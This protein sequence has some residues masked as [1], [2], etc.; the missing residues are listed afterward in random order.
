MDDDATRQRG[1]LDE[2]GVQGLPVELDRI[3]NLPH[4]EPWGQT[5]FP[6][7]AVTGDNP[8]NA[9]Q[10]LLRNVLPVLNISYQSSVN[11]VQRRASYRSVFCR[12]HPSEVFEFA[13]H[14]RLIRE[15]GCKGATAPAIRLLG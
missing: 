5:Q 2:F 7:S 14:M 13:V 9:W 12:P 15:A 6:V 8:H 10:R 11:M 3:I 1:A 4:N